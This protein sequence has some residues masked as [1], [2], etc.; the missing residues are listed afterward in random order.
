M[1]HL[2]LF[3]LIGVLILQ[4]VDILSDLK[5]GNYRFSNRSTAVI[6]IKVVMAIVI[7]YACSSLTTLLFFW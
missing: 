4:I 3:L 7:F 6:L 2:L 1:F 5:S